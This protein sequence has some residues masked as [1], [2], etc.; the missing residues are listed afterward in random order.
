[1]KKLV[2]VAILVAVGAG[3]AWRAYSQRQATSR[4]AKYKTAIV[5]RQD[6]SVAVQATGV[7]EPEHRV[8]IRPRVSAE[9]IRLSIVEGAKVAKGQAIGSLD[10]REFAIGVRAAQAQLAVARA[11]ERQALA[12]LMKAQAGEAAAKASLGSARERL[13]QL[14]LAAAQEGD[15]G[16]TEVEIA[17]IEL[18]RVQNELQQCEATLAD[19]RRLVA[20]EAESRERARQDERVALAARAE[21]K[22]AEQR[23]REAQREQ[24]RR[25]AAAAEA[26]SEVRRAEAELAST[27]AGVS[28]AQQAV[29]AA[30]AAILYADTAREGAELELGYCDVRSPL[31]G[32]V[33]FVGAE[34]GEVVLREMGNATGS[35]IAVVSDLSRI[36]C[37]AQVDEVDIGKVRVGQSATLVLGSGGRTYRGRVY[38]IARQTAAGPAAGQSSNV[39]E[40]EVKLEVD[41]ADLSLR[42]GMT[43]NVDILISG[44][45]RVLTIP[46][47]A[48]YSEAGVPMVH[49]VLGTRLEPRRV[50]L[51]EAFPEAM[52]VTGGLREGD[53]V[54]LGA[55]LPE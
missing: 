4:L 23:L 8:N 5:V 48:I 53:R 38:S 3:L 22:K 30:R 15:A 37:R 39:A 50:S 44:R 21:V 54:V 17:K 52:E 43:L 49:V 16:H 31:A 6:M 2:I 25:V 33:T 46:H 13:H 29:E 9:L 47:E 12:S 41:N 32:V 42:P 11:E 36:I 51:G 45:Q 55:V 10:P 19:T 28:Q 24:D 26:Q 14:R 18:E 34:E 35:I 40:F 27:H 1:M 7:V 20:A